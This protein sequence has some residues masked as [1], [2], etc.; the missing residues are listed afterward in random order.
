MS[1]SLLYNFFFTLDQS[2]LLFCLAVLSFFVFVLHKIPKNI[3]KFAQIS[4]ILSIIS[5]IVFYNK[6]IL[7]QYFQSSSYTCTIYVCTGLMVY[8]CFQLSKRWML[9]QKKIDSG[10]FCILVLGA[11]FILN[12]MIKTHNFIVLWVL[13][14]FLNF[15]QYRLL[16]FS[17]DTETLYHF[18]RNYGL[19]A[20]LMMMLSAVIFIGVPFDNFSYGGFASD[21]LLMPYIKQIS[22][23]ISIMCCFFFILSVAPFHFAIVDQTASMDLPIATYFGVVPQ[24]TL[25]G[26]LFQLNNEFFIYWEEKIKIIYY[27]FGILSIITSVVGANANRFLRKIFAYTGVYHIAVLCLIFSFMNTAVSSFWLSYAI[28]YLL[29]MLGSLTFL[30]ALKSKEVYLNNLNAISGFGT[31]RPYI[32]AAMVFFLATWMGLPPFGIFL[33]NF[34]VLQ[35]DATQIGMI[36]A[37]LFGLFGLI[38]IYLKII[39]TLFFYKKENNFDRI[40]T[41]VYCCLILIITALILVLIKPV[42]ISE[43]MLKFGD[44]L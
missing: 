32:G 38:P 21:L 22:V 3:F 14:C 2:I 5:S 18:G 24:M 20:I 42:F 31:S 7:P 26:V 15:I 36:C 34:V 27:T 13:L 19:I 9:N 33:V 30:Y 4:V 16:C 41:S 44:M 6:G 1:A 23:I 37:V 43:Y 25:L 39:Q 29:L 10:I 28:I 8:M 17:R 40:D 12:I 11:L 35:Q